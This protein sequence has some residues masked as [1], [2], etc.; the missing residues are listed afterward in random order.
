M[1]SIKGDEADPFSKGFICPKAVALQDVYN[2]PDRLKKPVTKVN[3][4]WIEIGWDQAFDEVSENLKRIR[5][6]HGKNSI[7]I[8]QGNPSVHNYGT[9][10][11]SPAFV[12]ALQ[13]KNRFSAT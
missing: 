4:E 6:T 3:G 12:R 9:A 5:A 8:Y 7:G 11:F 2:D 10:L 13:T 1:L